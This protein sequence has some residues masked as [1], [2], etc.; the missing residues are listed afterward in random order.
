MTLRLPQYRN[1]FH[2]AWLLLPLPAAVKLLVDSLEPGI[3]WVDPYAVLRLV[4]GILLILPLIAC[5]LREVSPVTRR[6][7]AEL[8]SQMPGFLLTQMGV[9]ILGIE[10]DAVAFD[11]RFIVLLLGSF[12]MA[13]TLYGAEFANG[14]IAS[15]LCQPVRRS[16]LHLEKLGVLAILLA[17]TAAH[18]LTTHRN[19]GMDPW[20]GRPIQFTQ[21]W[22]GGDPVN[23][24][25]L[26]RPSLS[27][28]VAAV[29]LAA[30]CFGPLFT[31][32]TR[33]TIA[34][35]VFA[36]TFPT[37]LAVAPMI[38]ADVLGIDSD[39]RRHW[40]APLVVLVLP[41]L[42]VIGA[43]WTWRVLRDL[44]VQDSGGRTTPAPIDV[45]GTVFDRVLVR[46]LGNSSTSHL[47]RKELR[48]HQLA[49]LFASVMVG[50]WVLW[51]GARWALA[52][53]GLPEM[54]VPTFGLGGFMLVA[55]M[56]GAVILLGAGV[57]CVAEERQLGTLG[58][59]WTQPVPFARQWRIKVG[60][61]LA[62]GLALGVALP[63][64][65]VALSFGAEEVTGLFQNESDR[66]RNIGVVAI[67]ILFLLAAGIHASSACRN[68]M[69]AMV[70]AV[71]VLGGFAVCLGVS[72]A[73][74]A[75]THSEALSQVYVD[76]SFGRRIPSPDWVPPVWV[77]RWAP[78][79]L[80]WLAGLG[81]VALAV[82]LLLLAAR[83]ARR[84]EVGVGRL[85]RQVIALAGLWVAVV[86]TGG[87]LSSWLHT[88]ITLND[89][90]ESRAHI[91]AGIIKTLGKAGQDF[92]DG[93]SLL[94]S[95][96]KR[97]RTDP[98]ASPEVLAESILQERGLGSWH[99][100][101]QLFDQDAPRKRARSDAPMPQK[102][103]ESKPW[104]LK[105]AL[106]RLYG[107]PV[108]E[109]DR[110]SP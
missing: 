51:L 52:K 99:E 6:V 29:I 97:F 19:S 26:V 88:Q 105:P 101:S 43:I 55:G 4:V 5:R 91:L 53:D 79:L 73:L 57:S 81:F 61:T 39:F 8:R 28:E 110:P 92:P 63:L 95:M 87:L 98:K 89:L 58:W 48:L 77:V 50:L 12:W 47:V 15:W 94:A 100:I 2:P 103:P 76:H 59:Q 34:G 104:L 71:G 9:G 14:T 70:T 22:V 44:E 32:L 80:A 40:I 68:I 54:F 109:P 65:L 16:Q 35:A 82:I 31:L 62:V 84:F 45:A 30:F 86:A 17:I 37:S 25:W 66:V 21:L 85:V 13:A 60:T 24:A 7:L 78:E 83:N 41:I 74:F 72:V 93:A 1:G 64:C 42:C 56:F 10:F 38:V 11:A 49:R 18:V 90:A 46:L 20:M 36:F 75:N 67:L 33:S 27:L 3:V 102:L 107:L 108:P 106:A 69:S 96:R 23:N